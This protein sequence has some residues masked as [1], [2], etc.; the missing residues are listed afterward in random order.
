MSANKKLDEVVAQLDQHLAT[1]G[2][3]GPAT[4]AHQAQVM[5]MSIQLAQA[6][7]LVAITSELEKVSSM[8]ARLAGEY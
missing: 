8:L 5:A 6:L 1:F 7:A 3:A 4:Q 2:A